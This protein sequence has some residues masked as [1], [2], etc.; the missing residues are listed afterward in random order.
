MLV[1]AYGF[2]LEICQFRLVLAVV[3]Q[4]SAAGKSHAPYLSSNVFTGCFGFCCTT[5]SG[6]RSVKSPSG[7]MT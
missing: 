4:V 3:F 6:I 5:L 1:K 2:A 7:E